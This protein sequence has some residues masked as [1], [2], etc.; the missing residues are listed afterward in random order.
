MTDVW[1]IPADQLELAQ[2]DAVRLAV[3][4]MERAGLDIVTD[5]EIRRESYFNQFANALD[6]IDLNNP[7]KAISRAGRPTPVPR[8]VGPVRR[9]HPVLKRDVEF[10]RAQTDREIKVTVPGPFTMTRLVQDEHYGDEDALVDAYADAVNEELKDL[11]L[12]GA[13][14][15]QL[16]EPYLQ[17]HAEQATERGVAAIN[18]A[19]S[20]IG[21]P[22]AVHLCFG[23]AYVV[24]EKPSGYAFLESLE[25]STVDQ[26]S[27]EAAQPRVDPTVLTSLKSKTVIYGVIDLDDYTVET[28]EIVADRIRDALE[29][30]EPERLIVAPDCGM[31]YLPANIALAKLQAMVGGRNIVRG[32]FEGFG[33]SIA[34]SAKL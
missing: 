2:D 15:I 21:G 24:K 5:G 31:K 22:T 18:R 28:P 29:Y 8:V 23:Y 4:D 17:S 16:D 20:G 12:A 25:D 9:T 33:E 32:E 27:I 3:H 10:L 11:K 26:V 19:L 34:R 7:G 14:V 30:V 1:R 6:G 13:D